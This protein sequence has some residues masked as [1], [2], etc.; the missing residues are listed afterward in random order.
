MSE[1]KYIK[2]CGYAVLSLMEKGSYAFVDR[3]D[4]TILRWNKVIDW[5]YRQ[6]EE[7]GDNDQ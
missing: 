7:C 6:Y 1:E 2:A 3:T 5:L 4:G